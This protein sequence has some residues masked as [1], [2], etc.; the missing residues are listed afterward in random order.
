[1][2]SD[3]RRNNRDVT[4]PRDDS[5]PTTVEAA[6]GSAVN[7]DRRSALREAV[8]LLKE[9]PSTTTKAGSW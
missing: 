1:M 7:D 8:I 6:L 9:M 4:K 3:L 5:D 2:S